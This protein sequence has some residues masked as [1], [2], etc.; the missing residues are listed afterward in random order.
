MNEPISA[1][2]ALSGEPVSPEYVHREKELQDLEAAVDSAIRHRPTLQSGLANRLRGDLAV[3]L[4]GKALRQMILAR[5][6]GT[7]DSLLEVKAKQLIEKAWLPPTRIRRWPPPA[8]WANCAIRGRSNPWA[9]S[10]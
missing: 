4:R 2:A 8:N 9:G 7:L 1:L 10:P 5:E 6:F 3:G